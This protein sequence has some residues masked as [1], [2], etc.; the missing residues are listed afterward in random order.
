MDTKKDRKPEEET[1]HFNEEVNMRS[2][3]QNAIRMQAL[4]TGKKIKIIETSRLTN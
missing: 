1:Y 4:Y 3:L 2:I